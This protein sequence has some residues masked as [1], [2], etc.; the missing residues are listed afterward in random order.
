MHHEASSLEVVAERAFLRKLG[1]GCYVPV[2]ARAVVKNDLVDLA[3]I[4]AD[5]EG[6]R[7]FRGV[8]SGPKAQA[9]ALGITL[10]ERLLRQGAGEML[11]GLTTDR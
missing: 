2:G 6:R 11:A 3:G 8:I 1:G 10:A 5:T 9:T 7:L 4:V